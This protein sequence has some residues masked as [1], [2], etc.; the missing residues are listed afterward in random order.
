MGL[1]PNGDELLLACRSFRLAS[2]FDPGDFAFLPGLA[3]ALHI[4]DY[5]TRPLRMYAGHPAANDPSAFSIR[6]ESRGES[7][8]IHGRLASD[9]SVSLSVSERWLCERLGSGASS[10]TLAVLAD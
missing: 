8:T 5:A 7:A 1:N 10:Q 2:L 9:G 4:K 3:G 6:R